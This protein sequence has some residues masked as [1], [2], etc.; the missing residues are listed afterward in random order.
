MTSRPLV[1]LALL[2][3]P[4]AAAGCASSP[5]DPATGSAAAVGSG[6]T[7]PDDPRLR[8]VMQA[9]LI[10]AHDLM[11]SIALG[12]FPRMEK[13]AADLHALSRQSD[14]FVHDTAAYTAFS[15]RFQGAAGRIMDLARG[16]DLE[17]V[18][19]AYIDLNAS[20]IDCHAYLRRE[21]LVKDLPGIVTWIDDGV[22]PAG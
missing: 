5:D 1:V 12:D 11:E 17:A 15:E 14:W 7:S 4:L 6:G 3:L 20:C 9:K 10:H 16:H 18:S 8:H 2:A 19:E 22:T 21:G 13:N